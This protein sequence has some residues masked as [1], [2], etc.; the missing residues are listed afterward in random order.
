MRT[1]FDAAYYRRFYRDQ[2][3][4]NGRRIGR[5]A[6]GLTG[7]CGWWGIPVRS[8]LD[9]GAGPGFWGRW[10]AANRP[11]VRYQSIDISP[12]ACRRYGHELADIADWRPRR[13][14]DLVVCQGV[15][16][17]LD[18]DAADRAIANLIAATRGLLY[19]EVPT[20]AD[21]ETVVDPDR[22]DLD[23]SWRTGTWYRERLGRGFVDLGAGL[24]YPRTGPMLFYELERSRTTR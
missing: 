12:Y 21:R 1:D 22:T 9:V 10:L 15:L 6:E 20:E 19:L 3:V 18:D 5:L 7:L 4:H 23:I 13:P 2:P 14:A 17:Y 8:V 24:H 16:Q 11:R